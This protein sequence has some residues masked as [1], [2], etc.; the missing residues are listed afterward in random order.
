ML[1]LHRND[2]MCRKQRSSDNWAFDFQLINWWNRICWKEYNCIRNVKKI[3]QANNCHCAGELVR[4]VFSAY[5]L[6]NRAHFI[7]K[8]ELQ[9]WI[10]IDNVQRLLISNPW[11][12]VHVYLE[13]ISPQDRKELRI[14]V[15]VRNQQWISNPIVSLQH[16]SANTCFLGY[17]FKRTHVWNFRHWN[18]ISLKFSPT[19]FVKF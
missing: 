18:S 17:P 9:K 4:H 6:V 5:R 13:Q 8:T 16:P 2:S 14:C 3:Q 7:S 19:V 10:R 11:A 1:T 12:V 15:S